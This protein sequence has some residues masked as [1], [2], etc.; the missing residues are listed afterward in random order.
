VTDQP[1][2]DLLSMAKRHV[3]EGEQRVARQEEHIEQ[4]T[5]ARH[6]EAAARGREVLQQFRWSLELARRHLAFELAKHGET[7]LPEQ[8]C[9]G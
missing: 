1:A 5:R 6:P 7:N 4:M 3:L 9:S 2:E 8:P